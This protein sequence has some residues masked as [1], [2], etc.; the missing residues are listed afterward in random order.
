MR[1]RIAMSG[2]VGLLACLSLSAGAP[3]ALAAPL[4]EE[5]A[6]DAPRPVA[7][8]TPRATPIASPT[9]HASN[10]PRSAATPTPRPGASPSPALTPSYLPAADA[11]TPGFGDN[12]VAPTPAP[13]AT[14]AADS[15]CGDNP[16]GCLVLPELAV[17]ESLALTLL[18]FAA[19][20]LLTT[21]A[22]TLLRRRQG[23][24]EILAAVR[25]HNEVIDRL[26]QL[27]L[28]ERHLVAE[29]PAPVAAPPNADVPPPAAPPAPQLP[30]PPGVDPARLRAIGACFNAAADMAEP[31]LEGYL[32]A[33]GECGDVYEAQVLADGAI[34]LGPDIYTGAG[35]LDLVA[36]ELGD[37]AAALV[38]SFAAVQ[39]FLAGAMRMDDTGPELARA[40]TL[41]PDTANRLTCARPAVVEIADDG[42]RLVPGQLSGFAG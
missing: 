23:A 40:F 28:R 18:G 1:V 6:A 41:S 30:L 27:Q 37:D 7:S 38:P 2:L 33:L 39:R 3:A 42:L 24:A 19:G 21:L 14:K 16:G 34:T 8:P 17:W 15:A 25:R 31:S 20:V 5:D 10:T 12:P 36:L 35:D 22:F 4:Q 11:A 9:P 29:V 32:A 13:K 26:N